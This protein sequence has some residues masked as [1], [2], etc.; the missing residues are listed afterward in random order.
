VLFFKKGR[1]GSA[2]WVLPK[3]RRCAGE[4]DE[5]AAARQVLDSSG[6]SSVVALRELPPQEY[7]EEWRGRVAVRRVTYFLMRCDAS[8]GDLRVRRAEGFRKCKW[9]TFDEALARTAPS[10]AHRALRAAQAFVY[11]NGRPRGFECA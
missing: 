2:R 9:L 8:D 3:G 11:G 5:E 1:G 10:R 4:S 7:F 6:L